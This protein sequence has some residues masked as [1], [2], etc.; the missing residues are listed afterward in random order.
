[1]IKYFNFKVLGVFIAFQLIWTTTVAQIQSGADSYAYTPQYSNFDNFTAAGDLSLQIGSGALSI[2]VLPSAR[3]SFSPIE[4]F[5]LG[6]NYFA[7]SNSTTQFDQQQTNAKIVSGDVFYYK[8]LMETEKTELRWRLGAGYGSG[9]VNRKY[10]N[11]FTG[12]ANLGIQ[13]YMLESGFMLYT[14]NMGFG[15]GLRGKYFNFSNQEG[16][17]EVSER[18]L[19]KLNYLIAVAPAFLVDLNTR[20]EFGGDLGRLFVS[21]DNTLNNFK[22]ENDIISSLIDRSSVHIGFYLLLNKAINKKK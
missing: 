1:M 2:S 4:N 16:F 8:H 21:F 13:K 22:N 12:G 9:T 20:F 5:G 3:L 14:S 7:Y 6:I 15:I 18:E 17:G 10:K 19:E 11:N